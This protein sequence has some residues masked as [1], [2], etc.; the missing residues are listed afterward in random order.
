[1]TYERR[2][3]PPVILYHEHGAVG[4]GEVVRFTI[5]CNPN[6]EQLK[7]FNS[8]I[9]LR[10]RNS[11]SVSFSQYTQVYNLLTLE[12]KSLYIVQHILMDHIFSAFQFEMQDLDR[13][14]SRRQVIM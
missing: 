13:I 3:S 10:V 12:T 5:T 11:A 1:M 2:V 14:I 4:V 9:W 8:K 6:L 7:D